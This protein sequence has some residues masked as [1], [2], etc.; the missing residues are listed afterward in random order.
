MNFSKNLARPGEI[1]DTSGPGP[2]V[3]KDSV[4]GPYAKE[5]YRFVNYPQRN[6]VGSWL[7]KADYTI[8]RDHNTEVESMYFPSGQI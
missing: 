5:N 6:F 2:D 7:E 1:F 8:E 4:G 3:P